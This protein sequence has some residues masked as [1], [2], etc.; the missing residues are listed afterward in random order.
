MKEYGDSDAL[1]I[2]KS[3]IFEP[4]QVEYIQ[5]NSNIVVVNVERSLPDAIVSHYHHLRRLRKAPERMRLYFSLIGK[6]KAMRMMNYR[7]Q[8]DFVSERNIGV[9]YEDLLDD[10]DAQIARLLACFGQYCNDV[11]DVGERTSLASLR[12]KSSEYGL[13]EPPSS[14]G[15]GARAKVPR[16]SSR[17]SSTRSCASSMASTAVSNASLISYRLNNGLGSRGGWRTISSR[18]SLHRQEDVVT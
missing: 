16:Y 8:W 7:R 18:L 6:Y 17:M 5:V 3:R 12:K 11:V 4:D 1:Y 10:L 9:Q 14:T 15:K 2:S 13:N